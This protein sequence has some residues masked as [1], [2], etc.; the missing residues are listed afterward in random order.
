MYTELLE[1]LS[2]K[3]HPAAA[4]RKLIELLTLLVEDFEDK[5]YL[6]EST[7]PVEVISELMEAHDLKQKDLVEGGIFESASAASEVLNPNAT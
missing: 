4:E 7:S 6:I 2:S 1:N 5:S 3:K